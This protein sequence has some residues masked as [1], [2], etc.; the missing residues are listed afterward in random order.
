MG[1]VLK[2]C[3]SNLKDEKKIF[4]GI[5][6]S[7][8]ISWIIISII[9]GVPNHI[10]DKSFAFN[11][12]FGL[13][14][15]QIIAVMLVA[16]F[17]YGVN[18]SMIRVLLFAE[19]MCF[20]I[21]LTLK[22]YY[23][24]WEELS[25][26]IL[27]SIF[28]MVVLIAIN[29]GIFMYVRNDIYK[30]VDRIASLSYFQVKIC[31]VFIGLLIFAISATVTVLRYQTFS[32]T[33]FD[34]GIFSQI[35]ES[36]KRDFSMKTTLERNIILSHFAVHFSPI[37][38]IMLP[39]YMIFPRPE[40][41]QI[42][43]AVMVAL[44]IIPITMLA[45]HYKM[46]DK[47]IL[48]INALFALY[49]ATI[50]GTF[51]D[52]HENCFLTFL[53][54]M[55]IYAVEK[56]KNIM[57]GIFMLLTFMVKEDAAIYIAVIGLYFLFSKKDKK[58][59]IIMMAVA[60]AAF[61]IEV[62][63]VKSF[64]LGILDDR[65]ANLYKNENGSMAQ[66][67]PAIL[68][69]PAYIISQIIGNDVDYDM[70]KVRYSIIMLV[71]FAVPMFS[72]AKKYSRLILLLPFLLLNF[73]TTY[74]YLHEITFQYNFGNIALIIYLIIMNV[75][76]LPK[77]K[78][79]VTLWTSLIC[80]IILFVGLTL[81][82]FS[83]YTSKVKNQKII[84]DQLDEGVAKIDKNSS[85]AVAGGYVSAKLYK[86]KEVYDIYHMDE[87]ARETIGTD[88]IVVDEHLGIEDEL[89]NVVNNAVK[90]G[91]YKKIYKVDGVMAV[92]KK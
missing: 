36:M 59:G 39:I 9:K 1:K 40:T 75:S 47:Q 37:F 83:Y 77:E 5:T 16:L 68:G 55:A 54:L 30:L 41:I 89:R 71:P 4:E 22:T 78:R 2:S 46:S 73:V 60:I 58:R 87:E 38:Y 56:K 63:V 14:C 27:G 84:V 82:E 43:Q 10:S 45:K 23:V 21:M 62:Y 34:F 31:V 20:S 90:A 81:P 51:Y 7:F 53:L 79:R 72:V 85:V 13:L 92:Y 12:N 6:I 42:I 26:N 24:L 28:Y 86:N 33:T 50:Q 44:P 61:F 19:S 8:L 25:K 76:D 15:I 64:G 57:L 74:A 48:C 49:P 88:Y 65:F 17:L 69:N 3:I 11:Q 35:F 52:F 32:T 80:V 91:N 18:D 66:I 67:I 29:I 70:D